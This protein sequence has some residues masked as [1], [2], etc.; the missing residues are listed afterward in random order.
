MKREVPYFLNNITIENDTSACVTETPT[1]P[2]STPPTTTPPSTPPS[3]TPP[4]TPPSTPTPA[5]AECW[6]IVYHNSRNFT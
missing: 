3:T 6:K 1:T 4:T 5:N 2:P